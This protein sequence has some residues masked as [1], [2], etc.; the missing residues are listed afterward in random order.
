MSSLKIICI[1]TLSSNCNVNIVEL[2]TL[3]RIDL[4]AGQ[5][6]TIIISN[7]KQLGIELK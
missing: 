2:S 1:Y 6:K 3:R 4:I 5:K 7:E